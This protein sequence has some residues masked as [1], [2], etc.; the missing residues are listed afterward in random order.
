[1]SHDAVFMR[2]G[3]VQCR[4]CNI[5][6]HSIACGVLLALRCVKMMK[7]NI[8]AQCRGSF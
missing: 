8:N 6:M 3:M 7:L 5:T 1:V 2:T 4:K